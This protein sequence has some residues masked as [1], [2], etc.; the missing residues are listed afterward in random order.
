MQDGYDR[1]GVDE[2]GHVLRADQSLVAQEIGGVGRP[3]AF[4]SAGQNRII[5]II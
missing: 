2:I 3:D 5:L 1:L 4:H